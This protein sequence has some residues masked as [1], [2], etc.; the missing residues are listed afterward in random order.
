MNDL[1]VVNQ[2]R[3]EKE[4]L[5]L[6]I[7]GLHNALAWRI[8]GEDL[9]RK[10]STLKFVMRSF[11]C[12]MERLMRIE[13][14]DGY[15]DIVLEKHPHLSKAFEA[16]RKDHDEFRRQ[17]GLIAKGLEHVY[18]TDLNTLNK[19]CDQVAALLM[20]VEVHTQKEA[21]LFQEAFER[22]NGGEG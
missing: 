2:T 9:S 5:K 20:K 3:V 22:E 17:I 11:E 21:D 8:Y 14:R 6:L 12:H 10:L 19:I 7:E 1:N 16:L 15:M 13:E 18:P 4:M